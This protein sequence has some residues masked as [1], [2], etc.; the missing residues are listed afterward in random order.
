KRGLP[1]VYGGALLLMSFGA[2]AAAVSPTVWVAVWCFAVL[3][4][5]N[6]AAIVYNALLVQRG[7]PDHLRGRAFTVLMSSTFAVLGI[8]LI[9]AGPLPGAVGAR[10]VSAAAAGIACVA[11]LVG[12][13]L[14]RGVEVEER[15][16]AAALS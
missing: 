12:H 7:A 14:V 10:W 15:K 2:G 5:G 9:V 16:P 8:G 1:T 6:G 13:S 4:I 11:A 3:G